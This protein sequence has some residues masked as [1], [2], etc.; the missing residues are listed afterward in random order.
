M[1]GATA[2][3]PAGFMGQRKGRI[4]QWVLEKERRG[5]LVLDARKKGDWGGVW[6]GIQDGQQYR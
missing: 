3:I 4:R 6:A 5:L 1:R 2:G